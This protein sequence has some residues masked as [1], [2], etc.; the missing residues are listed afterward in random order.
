M[1]KL[2]GYL[3]LLFAFIVSVG[4]VRLWYSTSMDSW[5]AR[6]RA[7]VGHDRSY[8]E[9]GDSYYVSPLD[10]A[11]CAAAVRNFRPRIDFKCDGALIWL[12]DR[13]V[14]HKSALVVFDSNG[15]V[16][17]CYIGWMDSQSLERDLSHPSRASESGGLR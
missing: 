7:L 14:W 6:V 8:V 3:S 9:S 10:N 2:I 11:E 16:K 17:S 5:E 13:S 4:I 12:T 1:R 15:K